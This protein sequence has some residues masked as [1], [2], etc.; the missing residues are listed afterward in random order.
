[1]IPKS[2]E[3]FESEPVGNVIGILGVIA[4]IMLIGY[5][6]QLQFFQELSGINSWIEFLRNYFA[7]KS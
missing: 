1:V 3:D 5:L 4:L 7:V 2:D 6:P